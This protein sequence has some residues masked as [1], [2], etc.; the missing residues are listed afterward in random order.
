GSREESASLRGVYT[1]RPYG[2]R[3]PSARCAQLAA[4]GLRSP[5]HLC[6]GPHFARLRL[7]ARPLRGLASCANLSPLVTRESRLKESLATAAMRAA[8][9]V[10]AKGDALARSRASALVGR[11]PASDSLAR[12]APLPSDPASLRFALE[13][14]D[15]LRALGDPRAAGWAEQIVRHQAED[16]G[17]AAGQP[18]DVRLFET[19]MIA[20]H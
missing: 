19:G 12:L 16:G 7:A 20:G 3:S 8:A 1:T 15:D 4:H 11:A 14:C 9:Y 17:F 13:V 10:D 6:G 18:L 5:S 2:L